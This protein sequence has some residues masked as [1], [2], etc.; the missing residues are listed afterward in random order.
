MSDVKKIII[1]GITGQDGSYLSEYFLSQGHEVYG[2]TRDPDTKCSKN[3]EH[4]KGK[5]KLIYT[6]YDPYSLIDLLKQIKPT[7]IYN[8]AG[9]SSINKSWEMIEDTIHATA[10]LPIHL[11]EAIVRVDKGIKFFQPSSCEIFSAKEDEVLT[12]N[13]AIATV[14]PYGCSKAFAQNMLS[15]FR[16]KYNLFAATGIVFH[17]ES[18]RRHENFVSRKVVRAAVL[19]KLGLEKQLAL[20]NLSVERDWGYAP[21]Y[22]VAM[23][24]MM[25]LSAPQDLVLC[26]GETHKLEHLVE[27]VFSLLD[28]D[29]K[30]YVKSDP[31][32]F[33]ATEP[34]SVR[35]SNKKA[36]DLLDWQP[37][38]N[39]SAMLKKMV[40]FEMKL[41]TGKEK[42]YENE[43]P[44]S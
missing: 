20:G 9:Q 43:N 6:N 12:E 24:K 2:F 37:R 29:Y 34:K 10:I 4:L 7:E 1:T 23:A 39:F 11:L 3:I 28:L 35:G 22:V 38:V 5:V 17:H 21:D 16:K 19:I 18:P 31:V 30:K 32:F 8:F 42:D 25:S 13:S 41:Q 40:D 15:A 36:H 27:Q 14:S 26:T 33:R 44:F